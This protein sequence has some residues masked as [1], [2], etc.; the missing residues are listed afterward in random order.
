[1]KSIYGFTSKT[2]TITG[3][4]VAFVAL[5]SFLG[6]IR[7]SN[8]K[9]NLTS[10]AAQKSSLEQTSDSQI[11]IKTSPLFRSQTANVKAMLVDFTNNKLTLKDDNGQQDSFTVA[12][13]VAVFEFTDTTSPPKPTD[14]KLIKKD[15]EALIVLQ[16]VNGEYQVNTVSYLPK[17]TTPPPPP[18]P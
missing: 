11:Q 9:S 8:F 1:M 16:L 10:Q 2:L 6:G 17:T 12:P 5:I 13:N 3:I 4:L 18:K 7:Y 14:L 15:R